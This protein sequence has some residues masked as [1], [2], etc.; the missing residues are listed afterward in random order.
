MKTLFELED[1]YKNSLKDF[2]MNVDYA[3]VYLTTDGQSIPALSGTSEKGSATYDPSELPQVPKYFRCSQLT[4]NVE[5]QFYTVDQNNRELKANAPTDVKITAQKKK[6]TPE[7]RAAAI[8]NKVTKKNQAL[9][10]RFPGDKSNAA[11]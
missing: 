1:Q 2:N 8:Q 6:I 9:Q 5:C 3:L 10:S 7:Q 11:N 4:T